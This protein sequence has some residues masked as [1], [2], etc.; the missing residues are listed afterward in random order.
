MPVSRHDHNSA[1]RHVNVIEFV[2]DSIFFIYKFCTK[3]IKKWTMM[4]IGILVKPKPKRWALTM[5]L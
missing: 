2:V 4:T 3:I 5:M 1:V